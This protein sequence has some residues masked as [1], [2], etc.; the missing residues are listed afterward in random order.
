M[1]IDQV[2]QFILFIANK[3]QRGD[4]APAKFNILA[5]IAQ[6][7]VINELLGN[8]QALNERGVP[9]Y[10]YKSNR[11]VDESLRPLVTGPSDISIRPNGEFDYPYGFIWPDSWSKSNYAPIIELQEDEYPHVKHSHVIAPSID[12]PIL[13]FRN[14]YGFIDPYN[15]NTFKFSYLKRPPDPF[16]AYS[17]VND[18]PVYNAGSSVQF[19]ISGDF[20]I[21]RVAMKIL[22]YLG[23][24]L[25]ANQIVEL[26][27]LKDA[28][29]T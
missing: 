21:T 23:I 22:Q 5:P 18:E 28:K 17:N 27:L 13:I 3:E 12:Y 25:D 6:M 10:G 15:I 26:G 9:P 2:Y 29:G 19:T 20:A 8:N 7:E 4:F 24:N 1:T 16:W 11:K 14:P